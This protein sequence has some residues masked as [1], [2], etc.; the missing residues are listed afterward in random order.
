MIQKILPPI[1]RLK[2][3][4]TSREKASQTI[5]DEL[6]RY[7]DLGESFGAE[8]GT[9]QKQINPMLGVDEDMRSWSFYQILEHNTIVN[10]RITGATMRLVKGE[11]PDESEKKFN[12][13]TDV[14]PAGDAG[15]D[16][17]EKFRASVEAHLEAVDSL[18]NLKGTDT[19]PHTFFGPFDAH[20]WHCMFGFH[21]EIHRKQAEALSRLVLR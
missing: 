11:P 2:F 21:L 19:S 6:V 4:L 8:K 16:E 9:E 3:A 20:K 17:V 12:V 14:M 7:L 15:A 13:K 10:H 1:I 5:Q 18:A